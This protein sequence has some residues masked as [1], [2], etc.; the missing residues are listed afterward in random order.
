VGPGNVGGRTRS[1]VINPVD[2]KIIYA[3]SVAGGVWKTTN[4]GASWFPTTD[5]IPTDY[6]STLAIDP[7]EPNTLY[8]GTGES[9]SG[10]GRQGLG[11]LKTSDAG[12]TWARLPA[13][14]N[15]NFYYVYKLVI[16]PGGNIYAATR[17]GV[18]LS[19]DRG[20]TWTQSFIKFACYEM[21][22]RPDQPE[23]LFVNCSTTTSTAGPFAIYRN[24]GPT[25]GGA[26][27]QVFTTTGMART[28]LAIAQSQPTTIYAMSWS[29]SPQPTN[30]TGLI[31]VF[32]SISSG[33]T[34][35]WTMRTS[36]A[37]TVRL[38]TGLLSNPSGLFAD[39]CSNGTP[40]YGG[41]GGYDN[42]LAVDPV[43]PD[44]VWAGGVDVFRSDDGGANWGLAS[45]WNRSGS[46][47]AHADRHAIVFHPDYDGTTNQTL[48]LG[49]DGGIFRTD[50]ANAPV[51]TGNRA[52]CSPNKSDI[53]WINL[54]HN[55]AVT[56]F[57]HGRP[58]PGGSAY[59]GGAQDN[60]TPRGV[61][62]TGT[63]GWRSIFGGDGG[64]I[65]I[66]PA[67]PNSIFYEYVNL[68]TYRSVNGGASTLDATHGVSEAS[69]NFQFLKTIAMD[70]ADGQ[71]LF[72]GGKT[73][74]RSIDGA[75]SWTEASAAVNDTI[76]AITVSPS[77]PNTVMFSGT[78]GNI[79]YSGNALRTDR[80]TVWSSS[81]PRANAAAATIAI[82]PNNSDVV[83]VVYPAFKSAAADNHVYK[84]TDGGKTWKGVD[85][86]GTTGIPDVP[87]NSVLIDP[88]NSD[89]VYL[90][91]DLGIYVS[92]DGGS[93]W[94]RD[95]N[96]FV[97]TPITTLSLERGSGVTWLFAFTYGRGAWKT[98]VPDGGSACQYTLDQSSLTL[99]AGGGTGS[100][101]VETG[102]GCVWSAVSADNIIVPQSPAGGTGPGKIYFTA[103]ANTTAAQRTSVLS[104]Q[105]QSLR[106][107]LSG[108]DTTATNDEPDTAVPVTTLPFSASV[109]T[110]YTGS[111]TDPVHS[112]TGSRDLSTAWYKFTA[113]ATGAITVA[114][115]GVSVLSS[116]R[117][118][119]GGGIG[120]E[121][122]CTTNSGAGFTF[123][124][125]I[126]VTAGQ[127]LYW[128]V[129]SRAAAAAGR[130]ITIAM[131][132]TA[133]RTVTVKTDRETIG[134]G[135]TANLAASVSGFPNTAVRWTI[136][137]P[138]GRISRAGVYTAPS[139]IPN[140]VTVLATATAFADNSTQ[141][142]VMLKLQGA[143]PEAGA[144]SAIQNAA[145]YISGAVSP[146]EVVILYGDAFGASALTG[147]TLTKA[148]AVD[149]ATGETRVYFDGI[150]APMV[151]SAP[152]QVSVVV[153]YE[154][155]NR[156]TTMVEVQT[157]G[158]YSAA[159]PVAVVSTAPGLF[160]A[161]AAHSTQLALFNEDGTVNSPDN[162]A[163]KGSIVTCYGTGEGATTPTST[164]GQINSK[165]FPRPLAASS[166]RVGGQAAT[167]SYLGAA[168]S[169]VAGVFQLNFTVP[170]SAAS[171]A[172][173]PV[174][175]TIG[176][177]TTQAN[178]TMAVK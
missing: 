50:N 24:T 150:A 132:D 39:V 177:R 162:P 119:T 148:G 33:D 113:P 141:G 62:A 139:T 178:A 57:Y 173:V 134:A 9:Y 169:F 95:V 99:P 18:W 154:V 14:A 166:L 56:Q 1:I 83:F 129:S 146:G 93:T 71:R 164:N 176:G 90:G 103:S 104:V 4:A 126:S 77:D 59:F 45:Y 2:P 29:T 128:E 94:A 127:V 25:T 11:I 61:E 43:N 158:I 92:V 87:V 84:S 147:I 76:S 15:S 89:L 58:Y 17:T 153:P 10:D 52:A 40:D 138:I 137:P 115:Y 170:A 16:T 156:A 53:V 105:G 140:N 117:E 168:P 172:S 110:T 160:F 88:K 7:K 51:A 60:G 79:Y 69:A 67:D 28:S 12:A 82:D 151:Y 155:A 135:E 23:Y 81:R 47:Y 97:N 114:V 109:A 165:T 6:I 42:V 86:T 106:V 157:N 27:D 98:Q 101:N 38:N 171:G 131:V 108:A 54:N 5:L 22:A 30:K 70:P 46:E 80:T 63:E 31:G 36:N 163:P 167:I 107:T 144:V 96:P 136:S 102:P 91:S 100:V 19:T 26:W 35:S 133:P 121:F 123:Y 159:F 152:N 20:A 41:Q 37:D 55:Y 149:T 142:S 44:R 73:L 143:A 125:S 49:T 85:G 34:G 111:A 64:W 124:P 78:S 66:D 118:A 32:R 120:T 8:A 116:Y 161:D 174:V 65:A 48:F 3:G 75:R 175:L 72:I 68:A 122:T 74:W 21:A 112:C 145:S 13:T 130:A